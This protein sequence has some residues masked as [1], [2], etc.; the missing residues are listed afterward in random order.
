M[1]PLVSVVGMI[2]FRSDRRRVGKTM[3]PA[4]PQISIQSI[5]SEG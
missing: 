1:L 5:L 2:A 4:F 3:R